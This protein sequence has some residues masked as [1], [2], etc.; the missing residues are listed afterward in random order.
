MANYDKAEFTANATFRTVVS[1][2]GIN[3]RE[4]VTI[5]NGMLVE[6]QREAMLQMMLFKDSAGHSEE[7]K[8]AEV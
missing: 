5:L 1:E 4:A 3:A 8:N 7:S 6:W 2:N